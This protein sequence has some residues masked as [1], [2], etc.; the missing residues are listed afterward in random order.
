M[1]LA[2]SMGVFKIRPHYKQM[3]GGVAI[4]VGTIG[5]Y[6]SLRSGLILTESDNI[7]ESFSPFLVIGYNIIASLFL[8]LGFVLLKL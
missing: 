5:L 1:I 6:L 7:E 3:I 8:G 2:L 4:F